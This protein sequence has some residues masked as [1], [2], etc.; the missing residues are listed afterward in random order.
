MG[1]DRRKATISLPCWPF[2]LL[3]S[4]WLT[5]TIDA[6]DWWVIKRGFSH[7]LAY[8]FLRDAWAA[9]SLQSSDL[10]LAPALFNPHPQAPYHHHQEHALSVA[11]HRF[12]L[13]TFGGQSSAYWQDSSSLSYL[14]LCI[15]VSRPA[16]QH[17]FLPSRSLHL[18]F[19]WCNQP[20]LTFLSVFTIIFLRVSIKNPLWGDFGITESLICPVLTY[21]LEGK[22]WPT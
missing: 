22:L 8:E 1:F 2:C 10:D 15:H 4:P 19:P 5:P 14:C 11:Y 12:W 21:S 6:S 3:S 16:N 7:R 9:S 17:M 18:G 20:H 13:P